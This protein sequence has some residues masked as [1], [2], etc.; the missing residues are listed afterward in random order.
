MALRQTGERWTDDGDRGQRGMEDTGD[1]RSYRSGGC[2]SDSN[3]GVSGL[4]EHSSNWEEEGRRGKV[5][6]SL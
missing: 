4:T 5:W 1:P 3:S 6:G 2:S